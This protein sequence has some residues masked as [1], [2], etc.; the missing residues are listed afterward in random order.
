MQSTSAAALEEK[1]ERLMALDSQREK[2]LND[3]YSRLS[4]TK[5]DDST[6]ICCGPAAAPEKAEADKAKLERLK[7]ELEGLKQ[8]KAEADKAAAAP[9]KAEADKAAAAPEK[10]EADK[11]ELKRLKQMKAEAD[12]AA[13]PEDVLQRMS[14]VRP[15]QDS[16]ADG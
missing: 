2:V 12:K 15:S 10:A 13:A 7:A 5:S 1:L 11:A 14:S 9:E 4:K 3:F 6:T 16:C 8:M